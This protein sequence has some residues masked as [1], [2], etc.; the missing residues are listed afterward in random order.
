MYKTL[1]YVNIY[2]SYNLSKNSPVFLAH[3]VYFVVLWKIN[4]SLSLNDRSTNDCQRGVLC[5]DTPDT[6]Y[7]PNCEAQSDRLGDNVRPKGDI[8]KPN[9]RNIVVTMRIGVVW[10]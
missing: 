3:P 2:G 4:L 10:I 1:F 6:P 9:G 7:Q 5:K 8:D